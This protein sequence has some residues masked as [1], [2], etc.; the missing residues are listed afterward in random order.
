[1]AQPHEQTTPAATPARRGR[2]GLVIIGLVAAVCAGGWAVIMG[3]V[4][5]QP[6]IAQ[7]TITYSVLSDSAVRITYSVSKSRDD[8]VRC[9]VDAFD[10]DFAIVG[11]QEITLPRG[12]KSLTRTDTLQ[13]S[14][15]ATGARV[16]TC[17][18]V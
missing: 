10:T 4:G 3:N 9:V 15:R 13:T 18:K 14:K 12:Q 6:G 11:E 16:Q 17:R 7:Q 2:L 1:M 8:E 5:Q